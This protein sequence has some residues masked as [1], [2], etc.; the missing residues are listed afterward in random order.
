MNSQLNSTFKVLVNKKEEM[1]IFINNYLFKKNGL[2][3]NTFFNGID[4]YLKFIE[5]C[6]HTRQRINNT[7][8]ENGL[9]YFKDKYSQFI[10]A[11]ES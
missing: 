5:L 1:R 7:E 10:K 8:L 9:N 3:I 2:D 11:V 6:L 4:N